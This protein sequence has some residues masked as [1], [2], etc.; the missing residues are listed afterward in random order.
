MYFVRTHVSF[1]HCLYVF[2]HL[3]CYIIDTQWV[4]TG[5]F[6]GV[7]A[8]IPEGQFFCLYRTLAIT[9]HARYGCFPG[10]LDYWHHVQ[11]FLELLD[12]QVFEISPSKPGASLF[13]LKEKTHIGL[14]NLQRVTAV[15]F[16]RLSFRGIKTDILQHYFDVKCFSKCIIEM[17]CVGF[18]PRVCIANNFNIDYQ[19][20]TFL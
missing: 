17:W 6:L 15:T 1:L 13:L 16:L 10:P 3:D 5:T 11:R 9:I 8:L 18:E 2:L 7:Y 12:G 19:A 14:H 20:Y 4:Q